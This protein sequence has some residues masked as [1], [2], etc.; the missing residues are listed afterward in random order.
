MKHMI[1]P[2]T[3]LLTLLLGLGVAEIASLYAPLPELGE[4]DFT[5]IEIS[6]CALN[7]TSETDLN[8]DIVV[9]ATLYRYDDH[10]LVYPNIYA[11]VPFRDC[12]S[13]DPARAYDPSTFDPSVWTELDMNEYEGPNANLLTLFQ[14]DKEQWEIDA[15]IRGVILKQ[16]PSE[17]GPAYT[18]VPMQIRLV[19]SW[20]RF[21]PKG[22]A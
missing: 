19:G 3:G 20:R 16:A 6:P 22:A 10:I 21:T 4:P 8:R 15:E 12:G 18:L 11:D 2:I 5:V 7:S 9:Q 17:Y 13:P 1:A 14:T